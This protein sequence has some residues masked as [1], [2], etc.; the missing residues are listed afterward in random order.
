MIRTILF[1]LSAILALPTFAQT[2]ADADVPA[3]SSTFF[4]LENRSNEYS[5]ESNVEVW[6][7]Y[8][9]FGGNNNGETI[10]LRLYTPLNVGDWKGMLRLDTNTTSAWGPATPGQRADEFSAGNSFI[11]VWGQPPAFLSKM[12]VSLGARLIFPF[13]NYG[14]WAAGPQI[15]SVY[16]PKATSKT[17]LSDFSPLLRYLYGFD[18]KS[19]SFANN[20]TQPA[21]M[22]TL[23]IYPTFG[24]QL[25]PATQIRFW[26]QNGILYNSAGGN[27]F[28]PLDAMV[29]HAVNK[30]FSFALGA[31]KQLI[32]TFNNYNYSLYGRVVFQF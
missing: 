21:L 12:N 4:G 2:Q 29:T 5:K 11:T 17:M 18:T 14:Q 8:N 28:V 15:G 23:Q 30:D 27:W 13:G 26:E 7:F 25:T 31:S 22:R 16:K 6:N 19:N 24:I 9:N 10:N 3:S 1:V 20:P 32:Q